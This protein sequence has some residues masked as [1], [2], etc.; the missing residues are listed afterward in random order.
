MNPGTA[1]WADKREEEEQRQPSAHEPAP[2]AGAAGPLAEG[3]ERKG[4]E[5]ESG[6]GVSIEVRAPPGSQQT[7]APSSAAAL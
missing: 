5:E 3:V 1:E 4:V 2:A 6:K 7:V